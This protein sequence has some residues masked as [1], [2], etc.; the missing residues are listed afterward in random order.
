VKVLL[1]AGPT[2]VPLDEARS[3]TNRST[4]KTGLVIAELFH[5]AGHSVCLWLGEGTTHPLP[6]SLNQPTQFHTLTDLEGLILKTDLS[7]FDVILLPAALPDY[8]L[9]QALGPDNHPLPRKKWPGSL[10]KILIELRPSSRV[11]PTLRSKAPNAKVI[12]WKWEAGTTLKEAIRAAQQQCLTC[13][14]S[15]SVLNGPAYGTGYLLIPA[16]GENVPCADAR[17]LGEALLLFLN[18]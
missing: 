12:G 15:A 8:D 17:A 6:P 10:P 2:H 4:G 9:H 13:K 7:T 1:I 11:L 18:G 16:E 3:I 5:K 14:T